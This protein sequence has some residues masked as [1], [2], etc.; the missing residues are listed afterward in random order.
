MASKKENFAELVYR[1]LAAIPRGRV[2][3]YKQVARRIR[4]PQAYRAVGS[5]L[6][7]NP[8]PA[9]SLR[10]GALVVPCHRVV[11]SDGTLGGYAGGLKKKITLLTREGVDVRG[12]RVD[13]K[14]FG[15]RW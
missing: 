13:L 5:A 10:A 9:T 3:T 6:G 7:K 14:K 11:A 15:V 2:A 8:H 12:K 4:H 1:A